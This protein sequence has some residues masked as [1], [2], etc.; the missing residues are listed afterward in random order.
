MTTEM[1]QKTAKNENEGARGNE[2][3]RKKDRY[4]TYPGESGHDVLIEFKDGHP[5]MQNPLVALVKAQVK[6]R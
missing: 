2:T 5:F 3:A 6:K 1:M 4:Q